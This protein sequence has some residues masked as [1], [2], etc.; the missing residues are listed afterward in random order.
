M[1]ESTE[2]PA[3]KPRVCAKTDCGKPATH[4]PIIRVRAWPG[5]PCC[6]ACLDLPLCKEHSEDLT[7]D[8][9]TTPE[10]RRKVENSF[11]FA[12]RAKPD[13]RSSEVLAWPIDE[14]P[15]A[16]RN[17]YVPGEKRA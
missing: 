1:S 12:G 9:I 15:D 2:I 16:F 10:A 11:I 7:L 4:L 6:D 14:C 13:W 5:S 17:R 3:P 8:D